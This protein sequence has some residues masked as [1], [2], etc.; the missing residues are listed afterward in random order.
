MA[1][2]AEQ[3]EIEVKRPWT[4][5]GRFKIKHPFTSEKMRQKEEMQQTRIQSIPHHELSPFERAK[6]K[7]LSL[8]AMIWGWSDDLVRADQLAA[9]AEEKERGL[10]RSWTKIGIFGA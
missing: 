2:L 9:E 5:I 7:F 8:I 4:K 6:S 10:K 3:E 1:R